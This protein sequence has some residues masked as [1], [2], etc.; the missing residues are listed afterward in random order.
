MLDVNDPG[1]CLILMIGVLLDSDDR[2]CLWQCVPTYFV[3]AHLETFQ[4][5]NVITLEGPSRNTWR[6]RT[7]GKP[8][9]Q[10][11]WRA[12][13][14]DNGLREGDELKFTLTQ[15]PFYFVVAICNRRGAVKALTAI[16]TGKYSATRPGRSGPRKRTF[17]EGNI[18]AT[19]A[20]RCKTTVRE[21]GG[22]MLRFSQ[23]RKLWKCRG[24]KSGR[25]VVTIFDS[26]DDKFELSFGSAQFQSYRT[27]KTERMLGYA[28]TQKELFPPPGLSR[29]LR[30]TRRLAI[31]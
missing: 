1:F 17:H 22:Y 14:H 29:R 26:E 19:I 13:A 15:P 27:S 28:K 9:L 5:G 25:E 7:T 4:P 3:Q 30:R 18:E 24:D 6:V 8:I 31:S 10:S 16:N 23:E 11:G 21:R 12:F 2:G 20:S